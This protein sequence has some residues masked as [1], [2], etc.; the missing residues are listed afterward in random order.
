MKTADEVTNTLATVIPAA[1]VPRVPRSTKKGIKRTIL[2][3]AA[4]IALAAIVALLYVWSLPRTEY[5]TARVDRGDIDSTVTTTGNLNAVNTVQ[6]GSQV[7]GNIT[8][9]YADFN[10]KVKKVNWWRSSILL[11]FKQQ[12][13][14]RKPRL[15]L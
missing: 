10:T 7:S 9:L 6:V 3:A 1:A 8:A 2:M 13:T 4:L 11:L 14:R 12:S 5:V 15:T